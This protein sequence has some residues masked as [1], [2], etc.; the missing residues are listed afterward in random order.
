[1]QTVAADVQAAAAHHSEAAIEAALTQ[2]ERDLEGENTWLANEL[3]AV[4]QQLAEMKGL[5]ESHQSRLAELMTKLEQVASQLS[6][7]TPS[8]RGQEHPPVG[9]GAGHVESRTVPNEEQRPKKR[10]VKI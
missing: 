4:K 1:M 8:N 2:I 3:T 9:A 7:L 5:S 6:N 10:V